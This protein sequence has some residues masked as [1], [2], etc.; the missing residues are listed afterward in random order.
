MAKSM[1]YYER[2][3]YEK[4]AK[5]N[6]KLQTQVTRLVGYKLQGGSTGG[7]VQI[8]VV[9]GSAF[10]RLEGDTKIHHVKANDT[11]TIVPGYEL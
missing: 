3:R 2:K 5:E 11:F 8:N 7:L 6:A 10:L 9:T 1:S 4:L